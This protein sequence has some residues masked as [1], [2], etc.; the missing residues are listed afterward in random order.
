MLL[1]ID[2]TVMP[3]LLRANGIAP[4]VAQSTPTGYA[5]SSEI[6]TEVDPE[7]VKNERIRRLEVIPS[8]PTNFHTH[9]SQEELLHLRGEGSASGTV[10]KTE[11]GR[12][13]LTKLASGSDDIIDLTLDD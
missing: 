1:K 6:P 13:S 8:V 7:A 2:V 5:H 3:D 4:Q 12:C 9:V 10:I 11:A